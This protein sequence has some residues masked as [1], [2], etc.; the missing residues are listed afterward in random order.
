MSTD[1]E[2]LVKE[3]VAATLAQGTAQPIREKKKIEFISLDCAKQLTEA[4]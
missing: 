2:K 1:I 3:A 4:V